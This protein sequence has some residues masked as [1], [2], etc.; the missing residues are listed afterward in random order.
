[1]WAAAAVLAIVAIVALLSGSLASKGNPTNTPE[2]Q[3]ALNL[4]R[5]AFPSSA[6]S[7]TTDLI[8][9]GSQ[10]YT[11]DSP[12]FRT[13][14]GQLAAEVRA[15][16]GVT[17]VRSYPNAGGASLVSHDRHAALLA[18]AIPN[19]S[20]GTVNNVV[21]AVQRANSRAG[22]TASVT[23]EQTVQHDLNQL[24]THDLHNGELRIGLP[25]AV[26]VLLLVFGTVVAGL[27]P[28][29][30]AGF[31]IVI[32]LGAVAALAHAFSISTFVINMLV[33]MGLAL[34]IDYSLFVISRYREERGRGLEK[35]DAIAASSNTASRAVLLSGSTFVVAMLG[36][37]LV[38]DLIMRSLAVGAIAVAIVSVA[39]ALTLLPALL[40]LLGDRIE[41]W[42]IPIVSRGSLEPANPEGRFWSGIAHTVLRHPVIGFVVPVVLLLLCHRAADP[43]RVAAG[44]RSAAARLP[45]HD[46]QPRPDRGG[47]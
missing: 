22:F 12:Q 29:A 1:V 26:I 25:A 17:S 39:A 16:K 4:E 6:P 14:V 23:G 32:A 24:S 5:S 41:R 9:V 8:V 34:G 13:L 7:A 3:R 31:A 35:L 37:L 28:L 44:I 46:Q 27:V 33:G 43:V 47:E 42:R 11:V 36:L 2:S 19:F 30:M 21:A 18:L 45:R 38:P 40:A 15:D 10:R 20:A